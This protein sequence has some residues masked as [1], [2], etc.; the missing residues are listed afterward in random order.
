MYHFHDYT[1]SLHQSAVT[2]SLL[3]ESKSD[4][5]LRGGAMFGILSG[6]KDALF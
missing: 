4:P 3:E 6:E 5:K 1:P 2:K